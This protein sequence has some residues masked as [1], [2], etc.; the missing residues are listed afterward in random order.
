MT[1]N[2]LIERAIREQGAF[3]PVVWTGVDMGAD[4]LSDAL[5]YTGMFY[6]KGRQSIAAP[7]SISATEPKRPRLTWADAKPADRFAGYTVKRGGEAVY[8]KDRSPLQ[9]IADG[10]DPVHGSAWLVRG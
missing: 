4:A 1:G 8:I 9:R 7:H 10:S 3:S 5:I 2:E 6:Y